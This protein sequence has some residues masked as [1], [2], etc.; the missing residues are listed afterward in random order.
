M[1]YV[2]I[3]LLLFSGPLLAHEVEELKGAEQPVTG[4]YIS[5]GNM[6]RRS[7]NFVAVQ[8]GDM[9]Y[10]FPASWALRYCDWDRTVAQTEDGFYCWANGKQFRETE[11]IKPDK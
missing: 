5:W 4:N 9:L 10:K 3:S 2:V 8:K 6:G 7:G 11:Q 1:K